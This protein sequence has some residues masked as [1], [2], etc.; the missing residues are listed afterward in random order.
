MK[1]SN[2]KKLELNKISLC[3]LTRLQGLQVKGGETG[4]CEGEPSVDQNC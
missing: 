3:K 4:N 2:K 1:K